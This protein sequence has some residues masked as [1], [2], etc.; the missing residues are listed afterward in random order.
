MGRSVESTLTMQGKRIPDFFRRSGHYIRS[1]NRWQQAGWLLTVTLMLLLGWPLPRRLFTDPVCWVIEDKDGNLLNA[2]IAADGQWRFPESDAVPEKFAACVTAFEDK[3]FYWH[4]GID[5]KAIGRALQHNYRAGSITEGGS[6]LSMQVIRLASQHSQRSIWNKMQE[7]WMAF[8]LET[9]YSKQEILSLYA[10]HAPFGSNVVGLDAAAWRYYGRSPDKLSWGEMATLAV[11]PNAPSLVHPGKNRNALLLKR[12]RLLDI[13]QQEGKL[14]ER[15]CALAKLERL[16]EKPL[17]LPQLAPHV[18]QHCLKQLGKAA[19]PARIATSLDLNWQT[20]VT[21]II[22]QHQLRLKGNGINNACALLMEVESGKVLA[23]VGNI[24]DPSNP[25]LESDVD[26]L[27]APRSPGSALKPL[28]YTAMLSDGSLLPHALL[29]DIPMNVGGYTPR[30]FDLGYD[31][32]VPA[33]VA[34]SRSLNIPAVYSLKQFKYQRFY[35]FLK[36]CGIHT[37]YKPADYYGLSMV[38]GGC[39]VTPWELA[40]VYASLARVLNHDAVNRGA[41]ENRDFHPPILIESEKL[42]TTATAPPVD[43]LS[44][45]DCFQAMQEVMRPG[46]EGLWEQFGSSQ[47]IAWKTGTS[48]G[49]RDGW[50][51]GLNP[52]YVVVVWTGNTDG[53][54]RPDLVG[55]KTAAPILFDI[56]RLLPAVSNFSRPKT[57][58][59]MIPVCRSTGF[60]AGLDCDGV[61]TLK[62]PPQAG[63]S[64]VCPYHKRIHLDPTG[65]Y[66][67]NETCVSPS[68]MQHRSWFV[69]PPTMEYYYQKKNF[70]YQPLPPYL[71]GCIVT[72]NSRPLEI[73][74]PKAGLKIYVPLEL[75]GEK[76]KTI[77]SATHRDRSMKLFWTIDDQFAGTTLYPHQLALNPA[78]GKHRVT[79]TDEQGASQSVPFEILSK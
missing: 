51:V 69:L 27:M 18:L 22:R 48:F 13:L 63:K 43:A 21:Q 54:G 14:T 70:G 55:I 52:K 33:S 26:V 2:Y 36:Q 74:Y 72:E 31:G 11:L 50:A 15:D 37:L 29:P 5:I 20:A 23:Y 58:Y 73:I 60:R 9:W 57:R 66:R 19:H 17:P 44:I 68:D 71:P 32:A 10:S 75:S 16:P 42:S 62:M 45:C 7:A 46:D 64:P 67:V 61:D 12:N 77:F 30:N 25:E 6:T 78:P 59:A 49:F 3:R 79:I 65:T 40:G 24:Y 47:R 76:G 39:E 28:L 8:R 56:F 38:L 41:I 4:P 53:E 34:L 1:L 35:D